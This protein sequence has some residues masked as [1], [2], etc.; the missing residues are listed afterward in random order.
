MHIF[1]NGTGRVRLRW[2]G[3]TPIHKRLQGSAFI[4][5]HYTR[6]TFDTEGVPQA[7]SN[8]YW[9]VYE[10]K[11][12]MGHL[13]FYHVVQNARLC[14][15]ALIHRPLYACP[16]MYHYVTNELRQIQ[17]QAHTLY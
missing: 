7:S 12:E 16:V 10:W 6:V 1:T 11:E 5:N 4:H 2:R 14:V 17:N 15:D 8:G 9:T 13:A 3:D